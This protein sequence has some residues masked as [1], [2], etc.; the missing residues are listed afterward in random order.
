MSQHTLEE[1]FASLPEHIKVKAIH[2]HIMELGMSENLHEAVE[3]CTTVQGLDNNVIFKAQILHSLMCHQLRH[4]N[5]EA[6]QTFYKF[7]AE[8]T[9]EPQDETMRVQAA[10]T[11][12]GVLYP[13]KLQAAYTLWLDLARNVTAVGVKWRVARTGLL[14]LKQ[15]PFQAR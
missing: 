11:L 3:L 5:L 7:F 10:C 1:L 12:I 14:L 9:Q 4:K 8:L 13:T 2:D 6:A 15:A